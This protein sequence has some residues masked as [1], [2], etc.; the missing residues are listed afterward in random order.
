MDEGQ[1][2]LRLELAGVGVRL[3]EAVAEEDDLGAPRLDRVHFHDRRGHRHHYHGARAE[4]LGREG[5]ALR[6]VA[7]R[8]ADHPSV[9]GLAGQPHHLIVGAAQ[10]ERKDALRVLALE[11]QGIVQPCRQVGRL[12]ERRLDRHVVDPRGQDLLEIVRIGN[13]RLGHFILPPLEGW[14]YN[15]DPLRRG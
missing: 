9:E 5:Y 7:R 6:V 12:L 1:A 4:A 8:G 10:L 2:P 15:S 13:A 11:Q 3:V 14:Q